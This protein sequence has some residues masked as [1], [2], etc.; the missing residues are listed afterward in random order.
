MATLIN[1]LIL[2]II[3]IISILSGLYVYYL[4]KSNNQVAIRIVVACFLSMFLFLLWEAA[5]HRFFPKITLKSK[6]DHVG[7][8]IASLIWTPFI[9]LPLSYF[10][11]EGGIV[12]GQNLTGIWLFQ[13]PTNALIML[14]YKNFSSILSAFN[15]IRKIEGKNI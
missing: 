7:T 11:S 15:D 8:F 13:A 14:I 12:S 2:T 1:G 4:S 5:S 3:N 10:L 9:F 6:K